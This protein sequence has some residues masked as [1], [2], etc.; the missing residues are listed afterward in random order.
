MARRPGG[1]PLHLTPPLVRPHYSG[2]QCRADASE[3]KS[4]LRREMSDQVDVV[5]AIASIIAAAGTWD[6]L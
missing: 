1:H 2:M 5:P 4:Y 3:I 6:R